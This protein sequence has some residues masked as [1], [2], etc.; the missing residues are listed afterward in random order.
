MEE[1]GDDDEDDGSGSS[2][3]EEEDVNG[4]EE[5]EPFNMED[6]IRFKKELEQDEEHK[7]LLE[8][9]YGERD[10]NEQVDYWQDL[11]SSSDEDASESDNDSRPV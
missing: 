8:R 4:I 1:N 10:P 3:L 6:Y 2:G 11:Q 7:K 5:E 9:V